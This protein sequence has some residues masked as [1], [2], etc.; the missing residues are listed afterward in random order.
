M[1]VVLKIVLV[2]ARNTVVILP[3]SKLRAEIVSARGAGTL[4]KMKIMRGGSREK[5]QSK[6]ERI[7]K[8][9]LRICAKHM[10]CKGGFT[11]N[12]A[13]RKEIANV[14]KK[15]EK[16]ISDILSDEMDSYDNMPDGIKES[17]NGYN[18]EAAQD[19]LDS[20]I[21]SLEEAIQYLEE[22]E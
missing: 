9:K 15:I 13:R 11:V 1:A 21:D 14:I 18:S 19:S 10:D 16:T 20:A 7:E 4:L 8:K 2:I 12:N 5:E 3:L 17:Q 22:I 6:R